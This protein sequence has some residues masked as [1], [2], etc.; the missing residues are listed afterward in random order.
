MPRRYLNRWTPWLLAL[1]ALRAFVPAGFMLSVQ[2]GSL[3]FTLCPGTTAPAPVAT[4]GHAEHHHH[5]Q[6][7]HAHAHEPTSHGDT[8]AQQ[9][10]G[11]APPC[12]WALTTAACSVE[13]PPVLG[14]FE[15]PPLGEVT[16]ESGF[17]SRSFLRADRIRGPPFHA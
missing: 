3:A 17:I 5:A 15:R 1:I 10:D 9:H 14:G 13:P 11:S 4:I 6:A 2:D 16:F 12:P 8:G 7:A